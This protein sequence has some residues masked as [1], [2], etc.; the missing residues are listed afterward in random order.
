MNRSTSQGNS[1]QNSSQ[2]VLC[3][4]KEDTKAAKSLQNAKSKYAHVVPDNIWRLGKHL[5]V[6]IRCTAP[7][8]K[9]ER[10][11]ATSDAFQVKTCIEHKGGKVAKDSEQAP[12]ATKS[13]R[14]T[15]DGKKDS[16][17]TKGNGKARKGR[18]L[19]RVVAEIK[20]RARKGQ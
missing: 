19:A 13:K 20:T 7:D 3:D 2:P 5:M 16:R 12:K 4:I 11:I 9:A 8:C 18:G 14:P 10:M 6:L 15:K 17:A 1:A